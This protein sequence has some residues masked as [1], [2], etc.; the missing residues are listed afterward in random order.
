MA[1]YKF[2]KFIVQAFNVLL[3]YDHL[4]TIILIS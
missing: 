3:L 1:D 4:D 2:A